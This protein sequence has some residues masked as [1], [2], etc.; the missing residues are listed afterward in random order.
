MSVARKEMLI[1]VLFAVVVAIFIN[2][3]SIERFIVDRRLVVDTAMLYPLAFSVVWFVVISLLFYLYYVTIFN[4]FRNYKNG[5][6]MLG[7]IF[8]GALLLTYL[9]SEAM[10]PL[11]EL[12]A[13]E[14]FDTS[15]FVR[16]GGFGGAG[17][18]GGAGGA[19]GGVSGVGGAGGGV[20]GGVSTAIGAGGTTAS[21]GA[22]AAMRPPRGMMSATMFKHLLV[23]V[24]NLLFVYI[25]RLLYTNQAIERRNEQ[26]QFETIK[27]QHNALLQQINPHFFFNSLNSLRY[28]IL[29]GESE[30]AVD[31]LDNLIAIFR[32]TLKASSNTLHTLE[33]ELSITTSYTHILERR[34]EGK[35]SV[36]FAIDESCEGRMIAPL[37][38]LTLVENV[39]KH[40]KIS[41]Q[42]PVVVKIFTSAA[43]QI[44]V[45]NNVVPKFAEEVEKSGIGLKNLNL[46]Y[47]LLTSRG[48][49]VVSTSERFVVSL[50]LIG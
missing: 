25:Q 43:D 39:V 23:L 13:P 33:E 4:L 10:P 31:Y 42:R 6:V 19:G 48:I 34:F 16:G 21:G 40:N 45:E 38:L 11:R 30:G 26:L 44:V 1:G 49:E 27:S 24:L 18:V 46:Q 41:S 15:R 5:A 12:F 2:Y 20:A 36:Q 17:G 22:A 37:T 7:V 35:F 47:E 32:K 28:I 8:L 14:G 3:S 29:K 9:F 50:P